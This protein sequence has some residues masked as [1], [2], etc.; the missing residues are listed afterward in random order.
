MSKFSVL[1]LED[2]V[3]TSVAVSRA[4]ELELP[5]SLILRAQSLFEARLLLKTY[6]IHFFILDIRL[7]DGC[8]TDLLPDI[9]RKNPGA[10]VVIVTACPLP[11]HRDS[12]LQYGV[13]HF[14]EK[15]IDPRLLG[16]LA[17]EY[18]QAAFGG[19]PGS[20]TS[21]SASLKRLA[22]TDIIQLKCLARATVSLEFT[23]RDQRHGRLFFE[24]GE[25][26]HAEVSAHPKT[27]AKEG[28]DAL[29]EIVSWRGGKV[30]ELPLPPDRKTI[31]APWQELLLEALQ[32]LDE[33]A[34][35]RNRQPKPSP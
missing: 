9:V 10:G 27:D 11:R 33:E 32:R 12:A 34:A 4:L 24:E 7:P 13:L 17:R 1:I 6:E 22:A 14:M 35:S 8:G 25:V 26:V 30:E 31:H 16:S 28:V 3:V 23:L 29:R 21:F 18:R 19:A 20:D 15:P 2:A 5:D